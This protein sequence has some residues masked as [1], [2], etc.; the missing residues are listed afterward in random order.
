MRSAL[1]AGC[2]VVTAVAACHRKPEP[3]FEYGETV[4]YTSTAA[5]PVP[6]QVP[7]APAA[8][9]AASPPS[10]TPPAEPAPAATAE[11]DGEWTTTVHTAAP[12]SPPAAPEEPTA[13]AASEPAAPAPSEPAAPPAP[14][15]WYKAK[16]W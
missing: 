10:A 12:P 16:P 6:Q 3:T 8:G 11:R 2:V 4:T 5:D 1:M 7:P 13:P 14:R 15:R 9:G